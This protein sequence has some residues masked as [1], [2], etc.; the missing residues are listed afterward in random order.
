MY[1]SKSLILHYRL[2][3]PASLMIMTDKCAEGCAY[4]RN[5]EVRH[6]FGWRKYCHV[7]RRQAYFGD[8]LT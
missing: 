4:H 7:L 2:G 6:Y 8:Y 3:A 5:N 1:S